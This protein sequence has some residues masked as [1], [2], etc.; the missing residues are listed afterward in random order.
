MAGIQFHFVKCW[1]SIA[2]VHQ[3]EKLKCFPINLN[4][5]QING[6]I[7]QPVEGKKEERKHNYITRSS[8]RCKFKF[9]LISTFFLF[10]FCASVFVGCKKDFFSEFFRLRFVQFYFL[11]KSCSDS[12]QVHLFTSVGVNPTDWVPSTKQ[13]QVCN[14]YLQRKNNTIYLLLHI[15]PFLGREWK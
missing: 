8:T 14:F 13:L 9:N 10:S 4:Q 6:T 15:S 12:Q 7:F 5:V 11:L 2:F 3:L 1:K